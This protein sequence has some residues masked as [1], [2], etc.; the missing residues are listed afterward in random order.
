MQASAR[1]LVGQVCPLLASMLIVSGSGI[2]N[3]L[4]DFVYSLKLILE[5]REF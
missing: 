3:A 2:S 4:D 1:R 5:A